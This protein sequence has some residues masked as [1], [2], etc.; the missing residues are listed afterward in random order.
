MKGMTVKMTNTK[1]KIPFIPTI[2][3]HS[4]KIINKTPSQVATSKELLEEAQVQSFLLYKPDAVTVEVDVYNI[5]AEALG[6]K[7]KYHEDCSIP[8]VIEHPFSEA[9]KLNSISFCIKNGRIQMILDAAESIK[10]RIGSYTKVSIG[11]SG[12]FSICAELAGFEKLIIDCMSDDNIVYDLLKKI[13]DHQKEYC[14][15]IIKR[16]L[17]ITLFESWAAPPLISPDIYKNFVMPYEKQLISYIREQDVHYIPLVIG[18]DTTAI[19]HDMI[20]T[21]TSLLISDYKT[22]INYFVEN[23]KENNL[24]IR[25]NIDPKLI[26][27]GPVEEII[28]QLEV[29]LKKVNGYNK[30]IVGSGVL[31]Y[32]TPSENVLAIRK[33]LENM[34]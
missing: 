16:G 30:F 25:G 27:R 34:Q 9:Y 28:M 24:A 2:F 22:D 6:C 32:N 10:K 19:I 29:M 5:E 4:A 13:L 7:I 1:K 17:G 3:E 11:I 8:G 20:E 15:E 31:P 18:G 14:N 26:E 12:P 33:Y 23:A 21:G